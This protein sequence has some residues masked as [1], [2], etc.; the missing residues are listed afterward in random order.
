MGWIGDLTTAVRHFRHTSEL[1]RNFTGEGKNLLR[2]SRN[3]TKS[4]VANLYKNDRHNRVA[5]GH[6]PRVGGK[7]K[8]R[9]GAQ[10]MKVA[11]FGLA[12]VT[13]GIVPALAADFSEANPV[14]SPPATVSAGGNTF[15]AEFDTEFQESNKKGVSPAKGEVA[16]Y[17]GKFTAAHTFDNNVVISGFFQPQYDLH[18][19]KTNLWKYYVEGDLG[20]KVKLNDWFTLTP[21]AGVGG[22]F[23]DTGV[24]PGNKADP[25]PDAAYYAFYLAGDLKLSSNWTWNVFN[26]RYRDAF[27][28]R[29]ITPKVATGL[30]YNLNKSAA[31]YGV[32][33]YSWKDTGT[34]GNS[35]NPDKL[36]VGGG[37]K[38]NF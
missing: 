3:Q 14:V 12:A 18:P 10:K 1:F 6:D 30:T 26:V 22:V 13:L 21:S 25:N 15:S 2:T 34:P 29:W 4:F 35:G 33:G 37:V 23:G 28:Y 11:F 38:L 16:D 27:S 17:Y 24:N 7:G 9:V 19:G 8:A 36:N 20:Y 5:S 32:V 31:L